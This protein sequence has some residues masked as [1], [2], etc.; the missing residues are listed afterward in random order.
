MEENVKKNEDFV[1]LLAKLWN[2]RRY[3]CICG[4]IG[5]VFGLMVAFSIPKKYTATVTMAPELKQQLGS[6]IGS[7]ASMM[8]VSLDNSI[9][10]INFEMLP[11]VLS[12]TPFALT[13]L[14]KE[15]ELKDEEHTRM[16]LKDYLQNNLRQPWWSHVL[17]APFKLLALMKDNPEEEEAGGQELDVRDLPGSMRTLVRDFGKMFTVKVDSKTGL[18][19]LSVTT[20]DPI[21]AAMTLEAMVDNLIDFMCNYRTTKDRQDVENLE[22]ICRERKAEYYAAQKA[23][24]DFA[25][26]NKKLVLLRAQAEQLKLQQEMQLAYQVYSQVATQLEGARIKE[27][28]SKPVLVV[29]E[30]VNIPNKKSAPSKVKLLVIFTFL[31]VCCGGAWV[32]FGKD[33]VEEFKSHLS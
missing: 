2:K 25:D 31:A 11:N 24:A 29:L 5:A 27:Q 19:T 4:A 26:S 12:S 7:I 28:Q 32:L 1:V 18:I 14:N 3:L 15:V 22:V 8:G 20:Q 13:I 23:Y 21:V 33:Y 6:G 16:P 9:D 30:P 10:A 17:G